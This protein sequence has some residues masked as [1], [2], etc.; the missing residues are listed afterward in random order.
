MWVLA[1]P[2]G[3]RPRAAERGSQSPSTSHTSRAQSRGAP[4]GLASPCGYPRKPSGLLGIQ[5]GKENKWRTVY[6]VVIKLRKNMH[7]PPRRMPLGQPEGHISGSFSNPWV[8]CQS[9]GWGEPAP[10]PIH[11]SFHPWLYPGP[12]CACEVDAACTPSRP[13]PQ[14]TAAP[15][16]PWVWRATLVVWCVFRN[17]PG[18]AASAGLGGRR[19]AS[20]AEN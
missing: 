3:Q 14:E 20:R 11:P 1:R 15:R 13:Y 10:W 9:G 2:P 6:Q 5:S 8:L 4:T 12:S 17:E 18:E 19:G 16:H 7:F